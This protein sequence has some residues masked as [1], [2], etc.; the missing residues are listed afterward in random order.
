[1]EYACPVWHS[2]L[3]AAQSDKI[4]S[5]QRRALL[6]IITGVKSS[7]NMDMDIIPELEPPS[8]HERREEQTLR[9]FTRMTHSVNCLHHLLPPERDSFILDK[10]RD[11]KQYPV[12]Y[13]RTAHFQ[14][15]FLVYALR[16]YQ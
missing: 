12:P 4:E 8:L 9:V 11:H 5:I 3:N 1:M 13:A 7:K 2:S 15:S 10:L 14:N 6:R 16:T